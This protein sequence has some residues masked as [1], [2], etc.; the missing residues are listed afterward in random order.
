MGPFVFGAIMKVYG[1]VRQ[2]RMTR[3]YDPLVVLH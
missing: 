2:Q 1:F 3:T